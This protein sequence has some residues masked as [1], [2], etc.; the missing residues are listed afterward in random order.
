[1]I[2]ISKRLETLANKFGVNNIWYRPNPV[3]E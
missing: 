2:A 1:M 3:D